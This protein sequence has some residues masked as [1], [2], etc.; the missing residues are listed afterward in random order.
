V[1]YQQAHAPELSL[2]GNYHREILSGVT[3]FVLVTLF[4]GQLMIIK[5]WEPNGASQDEMS[6]RLKI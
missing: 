5:N 1:C 3:L 4:A 2:L 6:L